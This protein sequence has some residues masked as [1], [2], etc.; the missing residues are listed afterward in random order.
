[1]GCLKMNGSGKKNEIEDNPLAKQIQG[2]FIKRLIA[3]FGYDILDPYLAYDVAGFALVGPLPRSGPESAPVFSAP[4]DAIS[5]QSL[6][7]DR[8]YYNSLV[9]DSIKETEWDADL[10]KLAEE[11]ASVGVAATPSEVVDADWEQFSFCRR[12][13]IRE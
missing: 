1:M 10:S 6:V 4:H 3:R 12:I 9:V 8:W 11:E 2:A 5:V 13:P 7:E